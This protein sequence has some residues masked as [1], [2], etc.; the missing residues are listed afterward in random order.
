MCAPDS[1]VFVALDKLTP[2]E[3]SDSNV[4]LPVRRIQGFYINE[5]VVTF[6]GVYP[7]RGTVRYIG[8]DKDSN[9]QIRTIVGLELV[10]FS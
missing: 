7:V 3:D 5:R 1:G 9:G 8:E 4:H 6:A 2:F 10:C